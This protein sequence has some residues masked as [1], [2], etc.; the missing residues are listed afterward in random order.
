MLPL[1]FKNTNAYFRHLARDE[2]NTITEDK[3]NSEIWGVE[4]SESSQ[5][6]PPKLIFYFGENVSPTADEPIWHILSDNRITGYH[7]ILAMH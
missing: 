3:W 4:H 2:M 1:Y 7:L 5:R 6:S